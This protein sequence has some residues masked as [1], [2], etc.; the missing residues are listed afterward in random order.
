MEALGAAWRALVSGLRLALIARTGIKGEL[1]IEQTM[2]RNRGNNPLKFSI[3]DD[4]AL[5]ALIGSGRRS[6]LAPADAIEDALRDIRLHEVATFAGMRAAV[7][8]LIQ[9][10]DPAKLRAMGENA[11]LNLVPAQKK[12]RAWD[13]FEALYHE[14]ARA[15]ADDF[16]GVFGK[17]F[18]RAYEEALDQAKAIE[19]E[20]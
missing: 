2:I 17:A 8:L 6:D 7:R 10:F 4:D 16:D 5:M 12:A 15:L 9:R 1:R 20:Q 3:D 19:T 13:A 14:T 11:R 18:A